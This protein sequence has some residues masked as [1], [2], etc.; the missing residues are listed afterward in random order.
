M[1]GPVGYFLEV[2]LGIDKLLKTLKN[3]ENH[4]KSLENTEIDRN[5]PKLTEIVSFDKIK[6]AP[7]KGSRFGKYFTENVISDPMVDQQLS[8]IESF[9][10][11][12]VQIL[13]EWLSSIGAYLIPK[14]T[15]F[16]HVFC[17]NACTLTKTHG[18][19]EVP[20]CFN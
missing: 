4:R 11:K 2:P 16:F 5:C 7:K 12:S 10:V 14:K 17:R 8:T 13:P 1:F 18:L 19:F 20:A 3:T 15:L 9:R 6:Y